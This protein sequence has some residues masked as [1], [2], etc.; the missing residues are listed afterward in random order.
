MVVA[1]VIGACSD[2][3]GW[4]IFQQRD[5]EIA[6]LGFE[7]RPEISFEKVMYS[8]F[9]IVRLADALQ[10]DFFYGDPNNAYSKNQR[11]ILAA[12]YLRAP[13]EEKQADD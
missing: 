13:L 12:N 6:L 2:V 8:E 7:R 5:A 1:W 3:G 9:R 10:Q 11:A 4:C